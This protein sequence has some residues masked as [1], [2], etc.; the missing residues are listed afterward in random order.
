[1]LAISCSVSFCSVSPQKGNIQGF[2]TSDFTAAC[3]RTITA[4]CGRSVSHTTS[5]TYHRFCVPAV[6]PTKAGPDSIFVSAL[7]NFCTPT[8][9]PSITKSIHQSHSIRKLRNSN[10]HHT[11]QIYDPRM[12]Q[13]RTTFC[14][15]SNLLLLIWKNNILSSFFPGAL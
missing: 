10:P 8:T 5:Y 7:I 12:S 15:V 11:H 9:L 4:A 6:R 14:F 3:F 2:Q 1:V 13:S